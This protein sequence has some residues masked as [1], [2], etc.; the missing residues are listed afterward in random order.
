M[1]FNTEITEELNILARYTLETTQEGLKIHSNAEP[2]VIAAAQRL[3][4]KG[5][6]SQPDG[7]YLTDLGRKATEHAQDL[8]SIVAA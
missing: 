8:L 3:F 4:D 5:L 7:G 1:P 6:I 2:S